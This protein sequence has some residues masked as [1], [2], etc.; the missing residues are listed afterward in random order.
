V[1]YLGR[2]GTP[3]AEQRYLAWVAE[4]SAQ[5]GREIT[6]PSGQE[7]EEES[8]SVAEMIVAYRH[9]AEDFYRRPDRT[10]T[11]EA[12]NVRIAT[13]PLGDLY[14]LTAA[15]DFGPEQFLAIRDQMIKSGLART[16]INSRMNIIRRVF[17]WAVGRGMIPEGTWTSLRAIEGLKVGRSSARES[18]PVTPVPDSWIDPVLPHLPASVR[19]MIELLRHTGARVGEICRMRG[20]D[21]D[22]EGEEGCWIYWPHR[23]KTQHRGRNRFVPIGPRAQEILRPW[24]REDPQAFIFSPLETVETFRAER[25]ERR[26]TPVQPSQV[27]R[28]KSRPKRVPGEVYTPDGV[29]QCLVRAIARA[30]RERRKR[31]ESEIPAWNPARLRHNTATAI[32]R[33]DGVEAVKSVLGHARVETS[34]LYAEADRARALRV[35]A[36]I[37]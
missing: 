7:P 1:I 22:L 31:G 18:G 16:T 24:L 25:R 2:W 6:S 20:A 14:G 10:P 36:R 29:R 21:L 32:R 11:G 4:W 33:A 34:Q 12:D 30:N 35:M 13:G 3:E 28:R 8:I 37:G 26:R 19:A 9:H 23:H 15:K 27:C 17:R 5:G